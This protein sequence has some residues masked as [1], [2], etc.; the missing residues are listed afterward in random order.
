MFFL[1]L[2]LL[3]CLGV[4]SELRS[5][6]CLALILLN[7]AVEGLLDALPSRRK[8]DMSQFGQS[9]LPRPGTPR[10]VVAVDLALQVR[11]G[12]DYLGTGFVRGF[13][14]RDGMSGS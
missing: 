4:P 12:L 7:G 14:A 11:H 9:A 6:L 5:L 13:G 3:L 10:L 8:V 1:L 2:L